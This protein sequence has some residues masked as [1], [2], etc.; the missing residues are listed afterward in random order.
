MFPEYPIDA[1]I[2]LKVP[3][4]I[5]ANDLHLRDTTDIDIQQNEDVEIEKFFLKIENGFPIDCN[6]NMILLDKKKDVLD[7]LFKNQSISSSFM[8]N[9]LVVEKSI[10]ILEST[11]HNSD[12]IKNVVFDIRFN[13][14]D[15]NNHVS[16]YN[17]YTIDFLLSVKLKNRV[18]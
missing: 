3:L 10:N 11:I 7:T 5:I 2:Q 16:I 13:T 14:Y 15:V 1:S 8:Q 18:N 6:I 12:E 17:D 9:N 4:N